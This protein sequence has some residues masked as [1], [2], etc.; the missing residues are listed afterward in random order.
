MLGACC[1]VLDVTGSGILVVSQAQVQKAVATVDLVL[2]EPRVIVHLTNTASLDMEA[3]ELRVDYQLVSGSRSTLDITTDNCF[4]SSP[5]GTPGVG[6]IPGGQTR[7]ES[8]LLPGIPLSASVTVRMSLFEDLSFEGS[9]EEVSF[10]RVHR[11]RHVT[12]LGTWI[13]ALRAVAGKTDAEAKAVL[14]DVLASERTRVDPSDSRAAVT[15]Q[16]IAEFLE[17]NGSA[18]K[19]SDQ[20]TVLRQRFERERERGVRRQAR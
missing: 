15:M 12:T 19:F 10:V 17:S 6:A 16:T 13:N 4:N 11:D 1:T 7:D 9:A 14:R 3:W 18:S 5:P 8:I 20:V 2:G